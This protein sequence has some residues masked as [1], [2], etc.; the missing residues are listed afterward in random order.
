MNTLEY[1]PDQST[2]SIADGDDRL[3]S[4]V[5]TQ[6]IFRRDQLN[7]VLTLDVSWSCS[8]AIYSYLAQ[9][10]RAFVDT[11][12]DPFLCS[13][14]VDTAMEVDDYVCTFVAG[15]FGLSAVNGETYNVKAQFNVVETPYDVDTLPYSQSGDSTIV[16]IQAETGVYVLTGKAVALRPSTIRFAVATG[17]YRLTGRDVEI[18]K[19]LRGGPL[20]TGVYTLTGYDATLTKLNAS[21]LRED[22]LPIQREDGSNFERE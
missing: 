12:G 1:S 14:F 17:V 10:Y 22:G 13:L 19:Q 21:L 9:A 16:D 20:A 5:G 3:Q 4:E 8:K 6:S 2:L 15:S 7:G 11:G 18:V